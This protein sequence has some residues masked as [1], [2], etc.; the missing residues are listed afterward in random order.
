MVFNIPI[1]IL[2]LRV[3]P[4]DFYKFMNVVEQIFVPDEDN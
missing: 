1:F 2:S 4:D 3:L